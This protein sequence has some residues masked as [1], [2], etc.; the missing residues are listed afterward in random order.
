MEGVL[1][2]VFGIEQEQMEL[3]SY[4]SQGETQQLNPGAF[5][6]NCIYNITLRMSK[7]FRLLF[8][9]F[10][11]LMI[12]QDERDLLENSLRFKAWITTLIMKRRLE[13]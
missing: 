13:M 12:G 10:D 6:R 11:S 5:L 4:K 3:L 1:G 7:P 2:C 9:C 8:D